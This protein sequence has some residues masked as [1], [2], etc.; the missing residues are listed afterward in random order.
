MRINILAFGSRGDVQPYVALGLGLQAKGYNVQLVALDD[1]AD[2][3][4]AYGLPFVGLGA[5]MSDF[6]LDTF[7]SAATSGRNSVKGVIELVRSARPLFD[8]MF[9]HIW[10]A[11]WET[12]A[13]IASLVAMVPAHSVVEKRRIPYFPAV[14]Q[15]FGRTNDFASP[16]F[17]LD[18]PASGLLNQFSH[19]FVEQIFALPTRPYVNAWRTERLDL[20]PL[21]PLT[22]PYRSLDG[23]MLPW[24]YGYSPSVVSRPDDWPTDSHVTGY[25]FLPD[26]A[27]SS[28]WQPPDDLLAFLA[29][30]PPPVYI[31]FGSMVTH[32]AEATTTLIVEALHKAR[33]RGVIMTGWG[34]VKEG[35]K[36]G[37]LSANRLPDTVFSID[38]CPHDWLFPQMAA[39]VHHGGAGTTAAGLRAGVPSVVVPFM[40]DQPFWGDQVQALGVGPAP[41]PYKQLTA[42]KLAYALRIATN[43]VPMWDRARA[44]GEKIRG[45]DGVGMAVQVIEN[46]LART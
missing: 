30:G 41:I 8:R 17:P 39:V 16:A 22:Y 14:V 15:P 10:E 38:S 11:C 37:A 26:T 28:E 45:E 43:H 7:Q 6:S 44:L 24:L 18:L 12:D 42:D 25:W 34:G 27:P 19:R 5:K 3:V 46:H 20:P 40:G 33:Q 21:Q 31:G 13:L 23:A 2:L 1:Y 32:H 35:F 4:T 29:D 36:Q 9:E